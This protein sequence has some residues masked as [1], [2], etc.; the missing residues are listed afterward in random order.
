MYKIKSVLTF[1]FRG[2]LQS[3]CNNLTVS[4]WN[5]LHDYPYFVF[6]QL[7]KYAYTFFW[8]FIQ[9]CRSISSPHF[10]FMKWTPTFLSVSVFLRHLPCTLL[11]SYNGNKLVFGVFLA[12]FRP[13][14]IPV[15]SILFLFYLDKVVNLSIS[16]VRFVFFKTLYM[17]LHQFLLLE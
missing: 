13:L 7:T 14:I 3:C 1:Q 2:A 9:Y 8:G 12:W 10:L 16:Q 15:C 4:S 11:C 17:Y 5:P 6:H